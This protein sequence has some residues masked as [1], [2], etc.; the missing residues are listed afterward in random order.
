[1]R[2]ELRAMRSQG[3]WGWELE[4]EKM[5][6]SKMILKGRDKKDPREAYG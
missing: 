4:R 6:L 1:M 2:V 5:F 3:R